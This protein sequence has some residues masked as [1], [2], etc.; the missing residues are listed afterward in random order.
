MAADLRLLVT[1]GNGPAECR[2]ALRFVLDTMQREAQEMGIDLSVTTS[3]SG[4]RHG[5]ASAIAVVHGVA[6][7]QFA[8]RWIGSI[9]WT[10]PSPVRP[11]HKRRNWFV[12]VM[13]F[14]T[15][16]LTAIS[17]L[18]TDLKFEAFRAGGAGGQHQNTTD[19]AV[20][21]THGPTGLSVVVRDQ[22][23]QHQNRKLAIE[24]IADLLNLRRQLSAADDDAR[25]HKIHQELERGNPVR[26]FKGLEFREV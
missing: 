5:P 24:R 21:A 26:C 19:S 18:E 8:K 13:P 7:A 12:G 11:L 3:E 20:R 25:R 9:Q 14:E 4:D 1:S 16:P 23:S 10:S 17:V 22:R 15:M 2:I 6:A